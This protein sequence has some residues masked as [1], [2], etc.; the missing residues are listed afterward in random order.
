MPGEIFGVPQDEALIAKQA[1]IMA[2]RQITDT[3]RVINMELKEG[4]ERHDKVLSGLHEVKQDIAVMKEQNKAVE[5]LRLTASKLDTR[6][7][8]LEDRFLQI[9]GAQNTLK[10]LKEF[11]PWLFALLALAWGLFERSPK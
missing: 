7:S 4:R 5:D 11:G 9:D 1:E 8:T 10:F 3:L 6:I 2:L